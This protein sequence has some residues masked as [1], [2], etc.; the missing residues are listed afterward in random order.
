[1]PGQRPWRWQQPGH[2]KVASCAHC[3][4]YSACWPCRAR[5][6]VSAPDGDSSLATVLKQLATL[7]DAAATH[8]RSSAALGQAGV[9]PELNFQE[10]LERQW[11]FLQVGWR[12]CGS[13]ASGAAGVLP[14]LGLALLMA[15]VTSQAASA[16][17]AGGLALPV[18]VGARGGVGC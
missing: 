13:G 10:F 12:L 18:V 9:S 16:L 5:R 1:M 3:L 11:R 6:P 14:V 7:E 15:V 17:P 2:L 4:T 8:G